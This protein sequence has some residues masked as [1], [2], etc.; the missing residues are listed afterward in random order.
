VRYFRTVKIGRGVDRQEFE[1]EA[2]ERFFSAVWPLTEGHRVHKRR[3]CVSVGNDVWEIDEFL[4]R[5]LVLAELELDTVDQHIDIPDF[6][7]DQLVRD[8]SDEEAFTNF[9]LA[10]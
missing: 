5:E 7:R 9:N 8:V 3:H 2:S 1:D 6:I 10:R 4:D